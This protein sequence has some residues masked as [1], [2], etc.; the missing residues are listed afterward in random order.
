MRLRSGRVTSKNSF[1]LP[2]LKIII[3]REPLVEEDLTPVLKKE[4]QETMVKYFSEFEKIKHTHMSRGT[5]KSYTYYTEQANILL[6]MYQNINDHIDNL[7]KWNYNAFLRMTYKKTLSFI[8]DLSSAINHGTTPRGE[9]I[10]GYLC[11]C[12][13]ERIQEVIKYLIKYAVQD[14]EWRKSLEISDE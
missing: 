3:P 7:H 10:T 12:G 14:L 13:K 4:F 1:Q 8:C 11:K 5:F 2:S 9:K 6:K